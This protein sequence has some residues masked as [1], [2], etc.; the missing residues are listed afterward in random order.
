MQKLRSMAICGAGIVMM[1]DWA[2]A[3]EIRTGK[4]VP[5]LTDTP[6]SS[7]DADIYVA[8]LTPQSAYRPMNVQAVMD[9]FVEKWEGGRCW[10][11]QAT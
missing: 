3:D 1:P 8:I 7:D 2:V 11:F 4:L 6:V 10:A 9:F 5:I